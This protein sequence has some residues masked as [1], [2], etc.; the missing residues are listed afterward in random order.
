[1]GQDK[2][3]FNFLSEKVIE[4]LRV[5]PGG[6]LLDLGCGSGDSSLRLKEAGFD[7]TAADMDVARF[8][9]HQQVTGAHAAAGLYMP[10]DDL[11]LQGGT[12]FSHVRIL[13]QAGGQP[14]QARDRPTGISLR[15]ARA[16]VRVRSPRSLPFS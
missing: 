12:D 14:R 10:L 16:C 7:V 3:E 8:K 15:S 6:K 9:H 4:I 1:M 11:R 5:K 2:K 13:R